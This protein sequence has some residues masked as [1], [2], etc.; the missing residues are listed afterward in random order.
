M[1]RM[2]GT[3]RAL[4]VGAL[5]VGTAWAGDAMNIGNYITKP[6]QREPIVAQGYVSSSSVKV[7]KK[8]AGD[9]KTATFLE[10]NGKDIPLMAGE[11]S[12]RLGDSLYI[13]SGLTS[14]ERQSV[15]SNVWYGMKPDEKKTSITE[16]IAD[17]SA[18]SIDSILSPEQKENILKSQW[19]IA[20]NDAKSALITDSWDKLDIKYRHNLVREELDKLLVR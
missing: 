13:I 10:Y 14:N 4:V 8:D 9:G 17:Y 15:F 1:I 18:T 6:F 2:Q 12:V 19:G 16:A 7:V 5:I 3:K 11:Q 20:T